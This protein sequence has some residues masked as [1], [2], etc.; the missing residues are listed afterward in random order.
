MGPQPPDWGG[1]H[2]PLYLPPPA[3]PPLIQTVIPQQIHSKSN[4]WSL[5]ISDCNGR[6]RNRRLRRDL[7]AICSLKLALHDADTDTDFLARIVADVLSDTAERP[8]TFSRRSSRGCRRECRC[9]GV[10]VVECELNCR[11]WTRVDVVVYA[12][13][14]YFRRDVRRVRAQ[15][16]LDDDRSISHLR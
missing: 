15:S 14:C 1:L 16:L 9:V 10:R 7:P 11:R 5:S 4:H 2:A 6:R 12:S 13:Q 8:P 3:P